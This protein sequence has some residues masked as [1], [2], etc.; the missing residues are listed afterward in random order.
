MLHVKNVDSFFLAQA[1]DD[2]DIAE[3][4][5]VAFGE[6]AQNAICKNSMGMQKI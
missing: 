5:Q 1:A 6:L 4:K 3:D 2:H